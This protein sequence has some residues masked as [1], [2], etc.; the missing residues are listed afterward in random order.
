M[1][2]EAAPELLTDDEISAIVERVFAAAEEGDTDRAWAALEPL[3]DAQGRQQGAR[4][5][6]MHIVNGRQLPVERALDALVAIADAHPDNGDV[7][8]SVAFSLG[9]ARDIDDLNAAPPS[10][11][12]FERIVAELTLR[13]STDHGNE[14]ALLNGLSTAARMLGR[15]HD[16]LALRCYERLAVLEPDEAYSHYN[17]GLL[18]KT[19]GRFAEGLAANARAVSLLGAEDHREPYDWNLGICATGAG[20]GSTALD[21]WRRLGSMVEMG[22]FG[23]PEGRYQAVKVKL[24]ERPLAERSAEDDSPGLEETVW[25]ERLS[26]CHGIIRSVLFQDLGV[27]YGDVVLFD[28]APVTRHRYGDD[29]VPVFPHLATLRHAGYQ[30]YDFLGTQDQPN[31][32]SAISDDLADD[33]VVYSHTESFVLLCPDCWRNGGIDHAHPHGP[34]E[35]QV[36]TGRVAAPPHLPPADLLA[37][38]DDAMAALDDC[39]ILVP[40]LCDSAGQAERADA[41]WDLVE[42]YFEAR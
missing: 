12:L 31:R 23:L 25:V 11:Q 14:I 34:R 35:H 8:A 21:V 6:L 9:A 30:I 20:Q 29:V 17:L 16:A 33:S 7:L 40:A 36:I 41:E 5:A 38:I 10:H 26:P 3:L 24:A 1:T 18:H 13:L 28:G 39:R 32:L 37:Q 27:E 4:S 2:D 15:Q 22:R 42:M 19:R